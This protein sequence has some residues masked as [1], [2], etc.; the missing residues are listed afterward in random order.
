[1]EGTME[2]VGEAMEVME[3]ATKAKEEVMEVE[4]AA[5]EIRPGIKKVVVAT[6]M[7]MELSSEDM[8]AVEVDAL[9]EEEE[10]VE[11]AGEAM[12]DQIMG[13]WEKDFRGVIEE[14]DF[15]GEIE[16]EEEVE[17]EEGLLQD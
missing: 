14:K 2:V 7:R 17:E 4:A 12:P 11:G 15:R 6:V 13:R 5:T 8:G 3:E 16:E 9:V 10:G 1:M